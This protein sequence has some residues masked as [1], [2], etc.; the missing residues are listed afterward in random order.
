MF[1]LIDGE[2]FRGRS[3]CVYLRTILGLIATAGRTYVSMEAPEVTARAWQQ[4]DR[5]KLLTAPR[6]QICEVALARAAGP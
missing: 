6:T 2:G 5:F 3:T 1:K 4:F